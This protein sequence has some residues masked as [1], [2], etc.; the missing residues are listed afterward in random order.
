MLVASYMRGIPANNR[1]PEK[2]EIINNFVAGVNKFEGDRGVVCWDKKPIDC[3]VAVIQG[4]VHERSEGSPHLN[5][6][7]A[8]IEH[9]AQQNKRTIIVDSN[10]FLYRDPGNTKRFLRYSYDG[11]FPTTGEYCNSKWEE[12]RWEKLRTSLNFDLKEHKGNKG[13]FI[14]ICAQRDGGWSMGGKRVVDWVLEIL[15]EIKK[16]SDRP[17]MLRF[18]PGDGNWRQHYKKL[19]K[20]GVVLSRT[21]T[22]LEDLGQASAV[23]T[24]NSSPGV[25]A[26]IEG[27]PVFVTDPVFENSQ[28]SPV[29][30]HGLNRLES[31]MEFDRE[32]WIRKLAMCHWNQ[33]DLKSGECW[34]WMRQWAT[35]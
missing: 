21:K 10:L 15:P 18:H 27:I 17:V 4:Y 2:P 29:A 32:T 31:P 25:A 23:I 26:A 11:V 6:R 16:H 8:V 14:L 34:A 22:L 5:L 24:Y 1:N 3:D 20:S 28:A 35:K 7:R 19:I 9:Q 33:E 13:K 30:H 12:A